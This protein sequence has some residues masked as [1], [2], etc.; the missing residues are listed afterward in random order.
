MAKRHG[1]DPRFESLSGGPFKEERFK[2]LYSFVYDEKLP[3]ERK[4]LKIALKKAKSSAAR[5]KI[6]A[7]LT[8]T[9]QAIRLEQSRRWKKG[10]YD[11]L[12]VG[13]GLDAENH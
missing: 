12:K 8:R 1:K 13:W 9:E 3:E 10:F 4:D 6:Q 7:D 2:K 5:A 11:N